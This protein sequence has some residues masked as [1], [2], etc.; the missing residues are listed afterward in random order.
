MDDM[1]I[2]MGGRTGDGVP[3]SGLMI[4]EL[5]SFCGYYVYM[6]QDYPSIIRGGHQFVEVRA[7]KKK[8]SG[9]LRRVD[10]VIAMNDDALHKHRDR[11]HKETVVLYRE[12]YEKEPEDHPNCIGLPM[13]RLLDS[14]TSNPKLEQLIMVGA[15]A[16]VLGM[17]AA[18]LSTF[19]ASRF[20]EDKTERTY[21][22]EK[23]FEQIHDS[24]IPFQKGIKSLP[25]RTGSEAVS[26]GLLQAGLEAY[27]AY[28][29]TPTSPILEFMAK[30]EKELGIQVTLPE[31]EIAVIMQALGYAYLGVRTALGTSGGGFSLMVEGLSLSGQAEIPV[32]IVL[33][34]RAG[35]G[36]GMPTYNSQS[37]LGFA[38][39]AGHGEFPRLIVA[40]GDAEE[41]FYWSAQAM[42]LAWKYQIPSI[43]LTDKTM[44]LNAYSFD[45]ERYPLVAP[46][47]IVPWD[48]K[49]TYQRYKAA[50]NGV[51]PLAFPP[52]SG[53]AVKTNSYDHDEYGLTSEEPGY[54]RAVV[55]KRFKKIP[56]LTQELET[57]NPVHV[58][59]EG[60]QVLITWG[61]NKGTVEEIADRMGM[62]FIQPVVLAPFP[63]EA[64]KQA[65]QG[66]KRIICVEQNYQGQLAHLMAHY[67]IPVHHR[68]CR[69]DG[70]PFYLEELESQVKKVAK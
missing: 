14:E 56:D 63:A 7:A 27:T 29:M 39:T 34:Q 26:L 67:G 69:Y 61:S 51:S 18:D 3:E 22:V 1:Q 64:V 68:I 23:G 62:K 35:P 13:K 70:R 44:G 28:P 36:T 9:G 42:N 58:R 32:V 49:G 12:D 52:L 21:W 45:H 19:P 59:G 40:P 33:G 10:A 66:A 4:A 55:E 25:V 8:I 50:E 41:A 17:D 43:I 11:W 5:L 31:S 60:D 30:Y 57:M 20:G 2:L 65:V 24:V 6:N 53:Q 48:E 38:L 47:E 15:M 37:E 54:A 16:R 46:Y